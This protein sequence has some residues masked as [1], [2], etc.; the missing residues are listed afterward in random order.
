[1]IAHPIMWQRVLRNKNSPE[2][3]VVDP[4]KTETAMAATQHY[5]LAPKSDLTLLYGIANLI[6]QSGWI[7]QKFIEQSTTGYVE[8]AE[9][10]RQHRAT[11]HRRE[12]HHW[13]MQRDGFATL[14]ER[15]EFDRWTRFQKP[16][17]SREG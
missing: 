11:W 4:R 5:A 3:I 1:C 16:G 6:I 17:A 15:H 12:Q 2:I 9:F 10:V 8:F 13:T 7:D 14:C